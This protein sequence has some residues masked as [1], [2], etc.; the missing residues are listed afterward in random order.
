[1]GLVVSRKLH[2]GIWIGD[3]I[4]IEVARVNSNAVRLKITAPRG[5]RIDRTEFRKA[6][7]G[8]SDGRD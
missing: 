8:D 6:A 1:M 7:K 2:E 4:L 3:D 5:V